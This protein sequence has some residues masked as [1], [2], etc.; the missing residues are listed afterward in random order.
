VL[1]VP[2]YLPTLGTYVHM[3]IP[4]RLACCVGRYV[5]STRLPTY[6]PAYLVDVGLGP[7]YSVRVLIA[8]LAGSVELR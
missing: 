5:P 4:N 3:Y 1:T 8:M 7:V 2:T 6:L